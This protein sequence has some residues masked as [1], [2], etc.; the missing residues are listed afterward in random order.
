M[1]LSCDTELAHREPNRFEWKYLGKM[2]FFLLCQGL[3]LFLFNLLIDYKQVFLV[4]FRKK[5]IYVSTINYYVI[6]INFPSVTLHMAFVCS[7]K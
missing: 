7:L 6:I 5:S 4:L 1:G 3:I 2:H